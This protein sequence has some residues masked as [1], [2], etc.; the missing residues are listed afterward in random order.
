MVI[1]KLCTG[2]KAELPRIEGTCG[3]GNSSER[4]AS[5]SGL[6]GRTNQ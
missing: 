1:S 3:Y 2:A 5:Q 6:N 4:E